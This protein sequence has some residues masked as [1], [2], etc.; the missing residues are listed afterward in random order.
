MRTVAVIGC[1]K[2]GSAKEGWAIGHWHARGYLH[3]D[4]QVRLCGVD[5]N[6][7]N[8][9]AFGEAFKL[10]AGQLFASTADLY[11]ALQ[12]DVV[13]ICTWPALHRAQVLEA[14]AAGVQGIICEKPVALDGSEIED[15]LAACKGKG[16][17]LAVA[18]QRCYE[19]PFVEAKKLLQSGVLGDNLTLEAR[20]GDGWDMLSW[21]VHWF[22]M[23][24]W[25]FEARPVSVLAGIEHNGNR[26][27]QHAVEDSSVLHVA[28]ENGRQATFITGPEVAGGTML[29]VR[30]TGGMLHVEGATLKVWSK[31][32]YREVTVEN[33]S[34]FN[35][36]MKEMLDAVERNTPVACDAARTA[37]ATQVALAAHESARTQKR[38]ALPLQ[39]RFAP[40][41]VLQ[42]PAKLRPL[43]KHAVLVAD[44]H[45]E[46]P[47]TG[48]S[49]RDG[50]L[51]AVR[52]LAE[53]VT[54]VEAD[55]REVTAADLADADLL[56]IYHTRRQSTPAARAVIAAW[57]QAGKPLA[58]VHCGIGAYADWLE[59]KKWSGLY[60]VWHDE[61]APVKS[62]HPHEPC[63]IHV[64]AAAFP[65]PWT[66]AW[67]P[68]DEVY[69]RLGQAAEVEMLATATM[70]DGQEWPVAWRSKAQRNVA[71]FAPGHRPD[72]WQLP[73][74]HEGLRATV[75]LVQSRK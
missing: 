39:T 58:I 24:A 23:A 44:R 55:K 33:A 17:K 57:V 75:E 46:D 9:K 32:G 14:V 49:G 50:V 5:P 45:H 4:P 42:H 51:A 13:S 41:E 3:A 21:S 35:G 15:M 61:D 66:E 74:M 31:S 34:G 19:P 62:G 38:I 47:T 37:T 6:A 28:F 22:D 63:T 10:P 67:L 27:Y 36:L 20:V 60:W 43:A 25:L 1:G 48:L 8:L 70:A 69:I 30:G 2:R 68:R 52:T 72:I 59:Y 26:R 64:Q 12:P 53:K 56:L 73:V 11:K 65:T 54:L 71:V 18:H 16:V 7:E 40:L 29:C